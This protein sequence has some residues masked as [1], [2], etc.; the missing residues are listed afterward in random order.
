MFN[1][2]R[3]LWNG[4]LAI[5]L[6]LFC[7]AEVWAKN[8][9]LQLQLH[10]KMIEGLP[11]SWS[12]NNVVLLGRDGRLWNFAPQEAQDFHKSDSS[13]RSYSQAVMRA[14]LLSEFGNR[15]DVSGTGHYLVV[16]PRGQRDKW[17]QRFEDLYRSMVHYFSAR[18][19]HPQKPQ[20][21]LVAI[22]CQR[23]QDYLRLAAQDGV[24]GAQNMLGYYLLSSNRIM[25]YDVTTGKK[26]K[27]QWYIN[28]QTIIHEAT[29]QTAYNI[30]IHNRLGSTPRWL[31][32][33]LAV[34]FE[35]PGVWNSQAYPERSDRIQHAML[36]KF[37]KY[38]RVQR[39]RDAIVKLI[40]SD[41]A[42]QRNP[43]NAYLDAWAL[44]FYL[45]ET[46]PKKYTQCLS[47]IAA[48][49]DQQPY[50]PDQ[51]L[52]DFTDIFGK[53]FNLLDRRLLRFMEDLAING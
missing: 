22:V 14:K 33:G 9:T 29:H 12:K 26:D 27:S 44:T 52:K 7:S 46:Q 53:N 3:I 36:K 50:L 43:E 23:K 39:G 17:A 40:S 30:G 5:C 20:F 24:H 45:A 21:P 18:G 48:L 35:A 2:H 25:L 16:H 28:A 37:N 34:M 51:R 47:K 42:F 38:A 10:G 4:L 8:W 1:N 11:I 13:F 49:P 32:E 15:Y 19:F 31:A 41:K 6:T